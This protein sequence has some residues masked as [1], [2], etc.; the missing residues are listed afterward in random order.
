MACK[1]YNNCMSCAKENDCP[2]DHMGDGSPF[3][4]EFVCSEDECKR[5]T[6]ISLEE[7]MDAYGR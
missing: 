1:H 4:R 2:Y 3:C 5:V 7:E 6:C